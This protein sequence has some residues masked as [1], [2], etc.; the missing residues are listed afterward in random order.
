MPDL[1]SYIS[2]PTQQ[3]TAK[4]QNWICEHIDD[5]A[6]LQLCQDVEGAWVRIALGK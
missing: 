3:R 4:L 6:F 5:D 2:E 1:S